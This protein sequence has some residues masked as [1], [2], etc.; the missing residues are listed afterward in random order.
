MTTATTTPVNPMIAIA[1]APFAARTPC[2]ERGVG[3]WVTGTA[4]WEPAAAQPVLNHLHHTQYDAHLGRS[5]C[6]ER[7]MLG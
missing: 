6:P 2:Q 1:G 4:E 5:A 7:C 3:G